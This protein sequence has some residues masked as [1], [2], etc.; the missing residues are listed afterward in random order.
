MKY[1]L[2]SNCEVYFTANKCIFNFAYIN[3]LPRTAVAIVTRYICSYLYFWIYFLEFLKNCD[4]KI[5][6]TRELLLR[7]YFNVSVTKYKDIV[8]AILLLI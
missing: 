2:V 3:I 6:L 4:L 5:L 1:D 8:V 7:S